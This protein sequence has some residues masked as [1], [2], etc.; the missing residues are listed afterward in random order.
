MSV[1]E[2]DPLPVKPASTIL[3][4]VAPGACPLAARTTAMIANATSSDPTGTS[5]RQPPRLLEPAL[6]PDHDAPAPRHEQ[7][8]LLD[9][10]GSG[11]KLA[12]DL[13]LVHDEDPVGERSDLVEVL[14][15][16]QDRRRPSPR[17][18]EGTQCTVSIAP[19]SRPRV[20]WATTR[21]SGSS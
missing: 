6:Q 21:T 4:Y 20:G 17:P 12:H 3:R 14:A 18:R 13:A 7:S 10:R 15:Q 5:D 1:A 9:R 19:T 2:S 16:Q 8:D 11:V